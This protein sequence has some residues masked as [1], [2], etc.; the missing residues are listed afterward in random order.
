MGAL[1]EWLMFFAGYA[2][3]FATAA[4]LCWRFG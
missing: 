2:F 4:F 3:G 1:I